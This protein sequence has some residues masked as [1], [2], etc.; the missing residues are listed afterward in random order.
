MNDGFIFLWNRPLLL[1]IVQLFSWH[2]RKLMRE[3]YFN[4]FFGVIEAENNDGVDLDKI[5]LSHNWHLINQ[6]KNLRSADPRY[7]EY[8][9][10][11]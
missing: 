1:K 8:Y 5:L 7:F 6:T 11:Y 3:Q 10:K 2:N 4:G 9:V